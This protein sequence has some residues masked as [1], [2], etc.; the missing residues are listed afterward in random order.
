MADFSVRRAFHD[1]VANDATLAGLLTPSGGGTPRVR[2]GWVRDVTAPAA[3]P[4]LTFHLISDERLGTVDPRT[5]AEH[6]GA[7]VMAT[8]W[9]WP[10]NA[11]E[12]RGIVAAE[13]IDAALRE[14]FDG[15][16]RSYDGVRVYCTVGPARDYPDEPDAPVRIGRPITM[17]VR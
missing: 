13:Q 15:K 10:G 6:F 2:W 4:Q 1:L 17:G 7:T 8:I 16:W 14:L 9:T 11:S 5:G 12:G 3:F